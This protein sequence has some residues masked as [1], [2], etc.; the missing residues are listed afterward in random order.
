[1][2]QFNL[3]LLLTLISSTAFATTTS[4][5]YDW[6]GY[7]AGLN[8]GAINNTMNIT[9]NQATTFYATIQQVS[10]PSLT[11]GLQIGYRRQLD[12]TK[13][14][15]VYGLEFSG[16]FANASYSKQYGSP[17]ALYQV[18]IQSEV[19]NFCLLQFIGGLAADR[20]LLFLAAGLSYTSLSGNVNNLNSSP[21]S[22][23]FSLD[24]NAIGTAFGAGGEY[25]FTDTISAR[26]KL[27]VITPNSYSMTDGAGNSYQISN[28]IVEGTV[29]LNYKFG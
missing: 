18:N 20:A 26:L 27:D 28:S 17:F 1:M 25:A 29:G 2:K 12:L 13:T 8:V 24:K 22:S 16:N 3:A 19:N 11:G 21:F 10:N 15:A 7:Y 4:G 23:S 5:P 14:S 9:D 6:T